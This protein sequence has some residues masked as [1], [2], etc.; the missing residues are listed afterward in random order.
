MIAAIFF[1][2]GLSIALG[3]PVSNVARALRNDPPSVVTTDVGHVWTFEHASHGLLRLSTDDSGTTNA[4]EYAGT[5]SAPLRLTLDGRKPLN[6]FFGRSTLQPVPEQLRSY[7]DFT[8]NAA[9]PES[10]APARAMAYA[11]PGGD[12]LILFVDPKSNALREAFYGRRDTLKREGLIPGGRATP[13]FRAP[14]LA[15]LGGADYATAGQGTAFLRILVDALGGVS[16]V[17][18]YISSGDVQLDRIAVAAAARDAFSP[19]TRAGAAV[20]SVY[21]ARVDFVRTKP[22]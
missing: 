6:L 21:F 19:A 17:D 10:S 3:S 5:E 16:K 18:V 13:V 12:E 15:K 8:A 9:L 4:I 14:V 7:A 1:A 22:R 20:P 11:L 2:G